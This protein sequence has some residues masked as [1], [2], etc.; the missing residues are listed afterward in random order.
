MMST[1][2]MLTQASLLMRPWFPEL[3]RQ[4]RGDDLER[5]HGTSHCS[6]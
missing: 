2:K 5:Q 6:A 4:R 1:R 3:D